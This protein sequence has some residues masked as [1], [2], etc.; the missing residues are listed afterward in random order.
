MDKKSIVKVIH[1]DLDKFILVEVNDSLYHKLYLF[2]DGD[3]D[4]WKMKSA[5]NSVEN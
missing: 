4:D 1:D 2:Y 3:L 5:P